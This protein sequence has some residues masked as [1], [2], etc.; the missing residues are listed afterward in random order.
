VLDLL[1]APYISFLEKV[2]AKTNTRSKLSKED[3]W[4][5]S[6]REGWN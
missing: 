6:R 5:W 2:N 3:P 4:N 1:I